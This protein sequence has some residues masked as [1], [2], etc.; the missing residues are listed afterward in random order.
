VLILGAFLAGAIVSLLRQPEGAELVHQLD[1]IGFGFFI[2]IFFIMVGVDFNLTVLM[3]SPQ[4][5]VL[6]PILLFAA[7]LVKILPTLVFHMNFTCRET[8]GAGV[9]FSARL[10]LIIAASAIGLRL[11]VI[12]ETVNSPIILVAII[13]VAAAPLI[14][15]RVIPKL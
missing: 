14:F 1:A 8:I 15:N 2:P 6:V 13:T 7:I 11:G 5:L 3:E 4:A 10:S 12:S 9:L